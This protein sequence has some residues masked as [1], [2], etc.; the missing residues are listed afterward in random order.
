MPAFYNGVSLGFVF[1]MQVMANPKGLQV[2]VYPGADGLEVIDQGSRGGTTTLRAALVAASPQALAAAEQSLR[3]LQVAGRA[4]TLVDDLGRSWPGV[5]LRQYR[6]QGRVCLAV[7][8]YLA[9]K[10]DA[11]FL[12]VF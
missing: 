7:N 9:R 1:E 3:S 10:Y 6:P 11:E 2:N 4:G 5:I 12:H 8:N